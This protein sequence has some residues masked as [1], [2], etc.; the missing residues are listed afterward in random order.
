MKKCNCGAPATISLSAGGKE[1][2][3]CNACWD[4]HTKKIIE[5]VRG[6]SVK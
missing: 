3:L 2:S 5:S 1:V 4:R 6:G